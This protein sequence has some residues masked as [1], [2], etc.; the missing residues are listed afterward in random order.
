MRSIVKVIKEASKATEYSTCILHDYQHKTVEAYL[1]RRGMFVYAPTR[2]GE[3][4]TL[5]LAL[6]AF[7]CFNGENSCN[8]NATILVHVVLLISLM[9]DQVSNI[10]SH[11]ISASYIGDCSE[12]RLQDNCNTF[13]NSSQTTA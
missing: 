8:S 12:H 13:H 9:K 7:D 5:E 6:H 11:G 2:A 10:N 3:S 4:L 1:P